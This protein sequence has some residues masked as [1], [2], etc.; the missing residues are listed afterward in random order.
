MRILRLF[1]GTAVLL[2]LSAVLWPLFAAFL[3]AVGTVLLVI[4][5]ALSA[6]GLWAVP[7]LTG[8]LFGGRRRR[9]REEE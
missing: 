4:G 2:A 1:F 6:A 8:F 7:F 9:P 3:F 5:A